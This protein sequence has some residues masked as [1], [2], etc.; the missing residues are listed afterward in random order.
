MLNMKN[1]Q[2]TLGELRDSGQS[3]S[4]RKAFLNIKKVVPL[5]VLA[6][7][8]FL[9]SVAEAGGRP[10]GCYQPPPPPH[11]HSWYWGGPWY[12]PWR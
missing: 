10:C 6:A 1:Q 4:H 3:V 8:P 5:L 11:H 9:S 12:W 2:T 7:A